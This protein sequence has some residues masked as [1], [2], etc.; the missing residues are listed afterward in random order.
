MIQTRKIS[1]YMTELSCSEGY[2]HRE[3]DEAYFRK[4][5]VR[6]EEVGNYEWVADKPAYTKSEYTAEVERLIG[7]RYTTGQ[8]IQFAREQSA[9]GA[10]YTEYLAYVEQCKQTAR[11]RLS[12]E[13][14]E[15]AKS[16][17]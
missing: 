14:R 17:L 1:E 10:A 13:G 3:G 15:N 8:E 16:M 9:A 7:E 11:Q 6:C 5:A 4:G 2:I 12:G